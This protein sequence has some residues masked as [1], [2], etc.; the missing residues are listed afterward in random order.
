MGPIE[1]FKLL[2][3]YS[4]LKSLNG[5][6]GTTMSKVPQ[7]VT[8]FISLIGTI[9]VPTLAQNWL[10]THGAVYV[11]FVAVALV[12]HAIFPSIFAAPSAAD[13]KATGLGGSATC[14]VLIGLML[15]GGL[16]GTAKAQTVVAPAVTAPATNLYALG[17][18]Y[19]QGAAPAVAGT[20]LYARLVAGSSTYAFTLIDVLPS[21]TKP[22]TVSTNIGA[23][24]AQQVAT[25][26]GV[27]IFVPTA[28]GISL[29]GTN[30][31]WSWS[32]GAMAVVKLP[33]PGFYLLPSVRLLKSSVSGGTGYQPV[34]GIDFGWGQ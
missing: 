1:M 25:I 26:D 19:N 20:A 29:T 18:S 32:T 13:Q 30:A 31:G 28:A 27:A 16:A 23:G 33:K 5:E 3:D 2:G 8:L 14:L 9:G 24:I 34:I 10:H 21:A 7:Y 4:K 12:L 11:I 6:K 15:L 22:Y 17:V